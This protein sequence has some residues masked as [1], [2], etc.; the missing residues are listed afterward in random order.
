MTVRGAGPAILSSS[1]VLL[2]SVFPSEY[3]ITRYS[4]VLGRMSTIRSVSALGTV[5]VSTV[6]SAVCKVL[7]TLERGPAMVSVSV[8][9]VPGSRRTVINVIEYNGP[10]DLV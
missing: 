2:L 7:S 10:L 1:M 3:A 4:P 8:V 5:H 9:S 6:T